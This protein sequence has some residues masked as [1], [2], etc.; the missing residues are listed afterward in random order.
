MS[1]HH[2]VI[3]P[4]AGGAL[5]LLHGRGGT[6][7]DLVGIARAIA[8]T[9]PLV[10]PRGREPEG[11][12]W[13]WFRHVR[14]GIPVRESLDE[15]LG[16]LSGWL[17]A[18]IEA[19]GVPQPLT[20]VG[21]SNGGM[22]AGALLAARPDLVEGVALVAGAY[23]LPDDL[24][25]EGRLTG[26]RVLALR[27]ARDPFFDEDQLDAGAAGYRAAGAEVEV[28]VDPDGG[29]GLTPGQAGRLEAWLSR[30]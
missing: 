28:D 3:E 26:R 29:H 30:S 10:S 7:G 21:F 25:P 4:G 19:E 14:I 17:D 11:A 9:R 6:E 23:P 16:E 22:M 13:A 15:R 27:G 1:A 2:A 24:L 18:I 8:P 12:G 20:A 5:L